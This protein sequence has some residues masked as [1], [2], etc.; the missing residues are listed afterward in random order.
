MV[1]KLSSTNASL[2]AQYG[3]V[4]CPAVRYCAVLCR[5]A[6]YAVITLSYTPG[7]IRSI[8]P[9]TVTPRFVRIASLNHKKCIPSSAR[10]NY[11]SAAQRRAVPCPA[12]C[13]AAR[14]SAVVRCAFFRTYSNRYHAKHRYQYV[15][16]YS[17]FY[18]LIGCP[19]SATP[20]CTTHLQIIT[21]TTRIASRTTHPKTH[22]DN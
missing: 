19:L 5:A 9:G 17:V 7:I 11:S 14:C 6:C 21:C 16:V 20:L 3:A 1:T 22:F 8:I 12:L 13:G 10:L 2:A 18:F 15:L 4:P